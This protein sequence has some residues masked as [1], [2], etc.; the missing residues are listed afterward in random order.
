[1]TQLTALPTRHLAEIARISQQERDTEQNG[2]SVAQLL[3]VLRAKF[4]QDEKVISGNLLHY[5]DAI[6]E[7]QSQK[8]RVHFTLRDES[9]EANE[10]RKH[11]VYP[12]TPQRPDPEALAKLMEVSYTEWSDSTYED[13]TGDS[14]LAEW[15]ASFANKDLPLRSPVTSTQGSLPSSTLRKPSLHDTSVGAGVEN[16]L[17][18]D[19]FQPFFLPAFTPASDTPYSRRH[20]LVNVGQSPRRRAL[21]DP[22]SLAKRETHQSYTR[23]HSISHTTL[24]QKK[25]QSFHRVNFE[26]ETRTDDSSGVASFIKPGAFSPFSLKF[27]QPPEASDSS[28]PIGS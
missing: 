6:L 24:S 11:R 5:Q 18:S 10:E 27:I 13:T 9:P 2:V 19:Q 21:S 12:A 8:P 15:L 26:D 3:H 14:K 16:S 23:S 25:T 17:D 4:D 20:I 7:P 28:Q 1:M 22:P